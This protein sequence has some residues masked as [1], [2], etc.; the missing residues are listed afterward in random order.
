M[1]DINLL[2][3]GSLEQL[4]V[5]RDQVIDMALDQGIKRSLLIVSKRLSTAVGLLDWNE[6]KLTMPHSRSQV[7]AQSWRHLD[8]GAS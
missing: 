6:V 1:I 4:L 2:C 8:R 7:Q 5:R 3:I